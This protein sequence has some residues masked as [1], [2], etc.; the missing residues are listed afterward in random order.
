MSELI[1]VTGDART[2]ARELDYELG[3]IV[4]DPPYPTLLRHRSVGTTTRL[5]GHIFDLLTHDEIL[6]TIGELGMRLRR[7][8]Y[9]VVVVDIWSWYVMAMLDGVDVR[10]IE[11]TKPP[12]GRVTGLWWRSPW[13][14]VK[15]TLDGSK[16]YGGTGYHG[17]GATEMIAILQ[18]PGKNISPIRE[19][20][21]KTNNV[22]FAPRVKSSDAYPTQ[23][24]VAL[25]KKL[26][27][28]FAVPGLPVID[29]FA[30]SG[31][32]LIGPAAERGV[33]LHLWDV[34]PKVEVINDSGDWA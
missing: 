21:A 7:G 13:V 4:T 10:D 22:V 9:A 28:V 27:D 11:S 17:R 8:A 12:V 30:G 16:V 18:A 2:M 3:A 31:R 26:L 34:E 5:K 33:D 14:W 6:S 15:T 19:R 1:R 25:G 29:P 20:I 24:P 23:K 32:W